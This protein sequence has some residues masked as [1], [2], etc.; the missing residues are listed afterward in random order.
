[1]RT[2]RMRARLD[3]FL[4]FGAFN[5]N[6]FAKMSNDV[7]TPLIHEYFSVF[8]ESDGKSRSAACTP[9]HA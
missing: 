9:T 1:M 8:G 4:L 3:F 5:F 2:G 7:H 6:H